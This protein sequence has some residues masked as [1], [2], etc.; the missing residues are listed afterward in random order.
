[1]VFLGLDI[2]STAVKAMALD[3]QGNVLARGKCAYPTKVDGERSTQRAEDWWSSAV[4]A[5]RQVV[6]GL[7]DP[8]AI[9]A[10]STSSQGGSM[11]ALD[12]AHHPLTDAMTWMDRRAAAESERLAADFGDAIYRMCGW[13]TTPVDCAAK[14]VWLRKHEP[15]IFRSAAHFMTTEEYI[16]YRLCGADVT[17]PTGAAIMRL[18]NI[19][20]GAWDDGMLSYLGV[21]EA[22]LPRVVPC[23]TLIGTLTPEAASELGLGADVRVYCGAHDQYCASIGSGVARPGEI[24]LATGTA[25]VIFG[26]TDTLCFNDH[27]IAPG[28]H[29]AGGSYGAMATL[30]GVGAA[31]ESFAREAGMTPEQ[32]DV[33][34][35]ERRMSAKELLCCPCPPG[36]T[37]LN[38]R[39]GLCGTFSARFGLDN[40][41]NVF[42]A[43]LAMME[44]AAFEATLAI[45]QFSAAGMARRSALTMSGGAARSRLWRG[46]VSAVTG[47]E[48]LLT[49][50]SDTPAL[51]AGIIAAAS[52]GA[53]D[54]VGRCAE[55]FVRRRPDGCDHSPELREFYSEKLERYRKW[56]IE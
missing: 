32:L 2:G 25:W 48:L 31:I 30:S 8:G 49:N 5:V 18:Y 6:G 10:L 44:G 24:L 12:D 14:L 22:K 33:G 28:R 26:V 39:A 46:I 1:M 13:R 50:E 15:E 23:G 11:L 52:H 3:G 53:F 45:E 34:A 27:Y 4:S 51:G 7:D 29:P 19:N 41:Y 36:R 56:C 9:V 54:S 43:G 38:H 16:N 42:D 17:D 20:T 37:F 21:S 47:R 55:V 40:A 35:A